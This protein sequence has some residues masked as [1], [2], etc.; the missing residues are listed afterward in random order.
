[1]SAIFVDLKKFRLAKILYFDKL[2]LS[3]GY[4]RNNIYI[5]FTIASVSMKRTLFL[6]ALAAWLYNPASASVTYND[7]GLSFVDTTNNIYYEGGG[8]FVVQSGDATKVELTIDLDKFN[9]YVNAHD[10]GQSYMFMWE[11]TANLGLYETPVNTG[12]ADSPSYVPGLQGAYENNGTQMYSNHQTNDLTWSTLIGYD[13]DND[14]KITLTLTNSKSSNIGVT[15]TINGNTVYQATG[16]CSSSNNTVSGYYINTQY[17][18]SITLHTESSLNTAIYENPDA[19]KTPYESS[20]TDG[21]SIGRVSFLG[22]SIT[23]G[24][25]TLTHRWQLFKTLVDNGI[26]HEIV[27]PLSGHDAKNGVILDTDAS[28]STSYGEATFDNVHLAQSSGRSYEII[29]DNNTRYSGISTGEM[30]DSFNSNT[31]ICLIGTN[32][33]LSD[34]ASNSLPNVYADKIESLLGGTVTVSGIGAQTKGSLD[35]EMTWEPGDTNNLGNMGTIASDVMRE[36]SDTMYVLSIPVW[37]DANSKHGTDQPSF[38]A[39]EKYNEMLYAYVQRWNE[40]TSDATKGNMVYVESNRGLRDVTK[41]SFHSPNDFFRTNNGDGLHPNEQ[42]NLIIAGNLAQAMGIGGRTAGLQRSNTEGWSAAAIGTVAAGTTHLVGE[43]A[44]TMSDGYTIDFS[45][46]F[47][48]GATGGWLTADNALSISLGDGTNSGTLNLSEGY[49]SWGSEVLFC[50]DNSTLSNEGN[51]R[52]AWHNGN[53]EDNVLSGYYVWLGDMLIGQGLAASENGGLNGILISSAGANGTIQ[54]LTWTDT[55]YAPTTNGMVS[56]ENAYLTQ[57]DAAQVAGFVDN[58]NCGIDFSNAVACSSQYVYQST[59]NP[60]K[61]NISSTGWIGLVSTSEQ[62]VDVAAQIISGKSVTYTVFGAMGA[63][64]KAGDLT[65]QIDGGSIGGGD[66]NGQYAAIAGSYGGGSAKSFTVYIND[67]TIGTGSNH[68]VVGGAVNGTGNIEQ[69]KIVLNGGS[70]QNIIGGS[71][72]AGSVGSANI[73]IHGGTV[74]GSI[75]AGGDEGTIG[76][77]HVLVKGGTITGGITKGNATRE[78]GAIASVTIEGNEAKIGGNIAADTVTLRNVAA[79][80]TE[81]GF[82]KYSR[83]INADKVTLDNISTNMLV[84][85]DT[86]EIELVNGSITSAVLGETATLTTLTLDSNTT[87]TAWKDNTSTAAVTQQESTLTLSKLTVGNNTTLNANVVFTADSQLTMGGTLSMGSTVNLATGMELTLSESM[88]TS[89]YSGNTVEIFSGV[90]ALF[91]DGN[92]A[93][94]GTSISADGLFNGID[95]AYTYTLSY[96]NGSVSLS[97]PEPATATL[98][99]LALAALAARRR[100]N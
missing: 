30:S 10:Y 98:S 57:Q 76:S 21:T 13:T 17:I 36:D 82:D 29:N 95:D 28:T 52:V 78:D 58:K 11:S 27:G 44:F 56:A 22:D 63:N 20:R 92:E 12:T 62:G 96:A 91:I 47:G 33:L 59:G 31:W 49:I 72:T 37:C 42:G 38:Q 75:N 2:Q 69:V 1:M 16:L 9:T 94:D 74:N 51:L 7:F 4:Y 86:T 89:L 32:D 35:W 19:Y 50:W 80:A 6:T 61:A 99:L 24:V 46:D 54:N 87:F 40:D 68:D 73:L 70:V 100:R 43:N 93:A 65:L 85:L 25:Q 8:H 90:D 48:N 67:G 88:L 3:P 18:T 45:A 81:D 77:T 14:G 60:T 55:A 34:T 64:T 79:S 71:K 83:S 97:I 66:C 26:E 41:D 23:H 39:T 5:F 15:A 53:T 84:Q